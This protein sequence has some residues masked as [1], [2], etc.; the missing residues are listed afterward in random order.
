MA[1]SDDAAVGL[2]W[3][4]Q[5]GYAIEA[6]DGTVLLLDPYL[7]EFALEE[8]GLPRVAPIVLDPETA[9]V[10]VVAVTHSHHDHLDL[11]TCAAL[12]RANPETVFVGPSSI[13]ARLVGRG[14]RA[15]RIVTL[16]RGETVG[17]GPF[18]LHGHYARH[19]VPGWL[20]EDALALVVEVAGVRILHSGDTEYDPRCLAVH[21][22]GPF[23][24]GIFVANGSGGCMHAL[25][26]ALMAHQLAPAVA[27]PCHYGMWAPEGYGAG[28]AV[29]G[30]PTLDP[31]L[32][33]V[34]CAKLGAP[35]TRVLELGERLELRAATS[36]T[37]A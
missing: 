35:A 7:S 19:E 17:Q 23:D 37:T 13:V 20:T 24:V 22:R 10:D 28:H 29:D 16:E 18:T 27:I 21:A 32:F 1:T 25:E 26:A 15:D 14:V 36:L 8:L 9:R 3:L 5:A 30:R 6:P 31:E 34:T 4:G 11:T 2:T 12:A 33:A